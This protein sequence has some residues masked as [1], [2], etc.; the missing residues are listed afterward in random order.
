MS[1]P[2]QCVFSGAV[3]NLNTS[4][5]VTMDNGDVITAWVSDE[6][7]DTATPSAVKKAVAKIINSQ[8]DKQK[9]IDELISRAA[10]LGLDVSMF[11]KT[12]APSEVAP[13]PTSAPEIP[14][15]A[16]KPVVQNAITPSNPKNRIID[17]RVADTRRIDPNVQGSVSALGS[18]VGG[19]GREYEVKTT[20]KPS[21]DLKEG[22]MAEIGTVKGRGGMDIAI[23]VKRVGKTGE[24][25]VSVIDT[26]GDPALQKRFQ[27]L[28]RAGDRNEQFDFIH[29]GYQVKT[30]SC[31]ACRGTGKVMKGR[32][33]PKCGG[34][35]LIDV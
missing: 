19:G 25:K 27:E 10:A 17:G 14:K 15:P 12:V 33:C 32:E 7:A 8:S 29:N 22:E 16:P 5:Q 1:I 21:Q 13:E 35:G 6:Y 30:V 31:G 28:K 34:A 4:M 26:G 3:G 2:K 24:T 11:K 20:E 9:E 23:P 18:S